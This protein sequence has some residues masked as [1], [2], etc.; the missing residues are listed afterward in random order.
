MKHWIA[1]LM[2]A[3]M[4]TPVAAQEH[5]A[6]LLEKAVAMVDALDA[7]RFEDARRDFDRTMGDA[8]SAEQLAQLWAALPAQVGA[9]QGRGEPRLESGQGYRVVVIPLRHAAMTVDARVTFDAVRLIAGFH[10]V[11]AAAPPPEPAPAEVV[12]RG[13]MVGPEGR[14]LPGTL[15]L[16]AG[17]G[18]FAAVV[19]VHGSGPQDRDQTVG[20][21]RVFRDFAHGL[22]ADGIASL[23]YEKRT[24]AY[25]GEFAGAFTVDEEV[26]DDAVAAVAALRALD[27]VDPARVFVLGHSFGGMLA[28]RIATRADGV[29]GIIMVAA[30]ARPLEDL[31][32]EQVRYLAGLAGELTPEQQGHV[33]DMLVQAAAVK[34]LAGEDPEG[35]MLLGLPPSYWRDL[36]AYDQRAATTTLDLPVLLL[37]GGRD[38][39]VTDQDFALW[40][41]TLTAPRHTLKRYPALNH[42]FVAG[43][44]PSTPREY[45]T[46]GAVA[47]EPIA[48]IAA[49]I[50]EVTGA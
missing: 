42:L 11:P 18:P 9:R 10:V 23:R 35:P 50:R 24:T 31:V 47:A 45:F 43:D 41:E 39:Q 15:T 40:R 30:P 2:V 7:G 32:V 38:Y 44:G 6:E 16:P 28:P 3:V 46:E 20:G 22:A 13:F 14:A 37:H 4:A 12:E 21:V 8:L 26:M 1:V 19:L 25:P 49:W 29:A 5:D 17:D 34:R 33:D 48:D 36:N 27:A